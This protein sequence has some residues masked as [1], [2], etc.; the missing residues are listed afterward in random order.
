MFFFQH[1]IEEVEDLNLSET[2]KMKLLGFYSV[3]Q[4]TV[5]LNRRQGSPHLITEFGGWVSC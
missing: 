4:L 5:S 2:K 1:R 3:G